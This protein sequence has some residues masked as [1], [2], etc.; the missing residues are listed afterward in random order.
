MLFGA[1]IA[2]ARGK[3]FI[4]R[5]GVADASGRGARWLE[6]VELGEVDLTAHGIDLVAGMLTA[7][8]VPLPRVGPIV[9]QLLND[10][11]GDLSRDLAPLALSTIDESAAHREDQ[12]DP[13]GV[14]DA[15]S[16]ADRLLV[17]TPFAALFA[18]GWLAARALG[19]AVGDVADDGAKAAPGV[20]RLVDLVDHVTV[21]AAFVA[22]LVLAAGVRMLG[23]GR[24][25]G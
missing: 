18:I 20:E 16:S 11:L 8:D 17:A 13:T 1:W 19:W 15:I 25:V 2:Q 14:F 12:D 24:D 22:A 6:A 3:K 21:P 23:G 4:S 9:E 7:A 5:E 10:P